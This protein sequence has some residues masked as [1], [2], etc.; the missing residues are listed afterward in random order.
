M[1]EYLI[2]LVAIICMVLMIVC[3]LVFVF[4]AMSSPIGT[5]ATELQMDIMAISAIGIMGSI[6]GFII[7]GTRY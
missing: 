7:T 6:F 5:P 3:M 4:T 1:K 2:S